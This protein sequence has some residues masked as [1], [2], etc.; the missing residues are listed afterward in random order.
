[1]DASGR[2]VRSKPLSVRGEIELLISGLKVQSPSGLTT[3]SERE[4]AP[5]DA[6][7][8]AVLIRAVPLLVALSRADGGP[9]EDDIGAICGAPEHRVGRVTVDIRR[10]FGPRE[11]PDQRRRQALALG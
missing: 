1:M 10:T 2:D 11:R 4:T 8:R 6:C 3:P 9:P 5:L 7:P